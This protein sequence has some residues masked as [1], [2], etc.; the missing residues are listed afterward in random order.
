VATVEKKYQLFIS[1]TFTDLKE[2]RSEVTKVILNMY[3]IPIG[4]EMFSASN[5]EQW[6]TIKET[7]DDSDYYIL[8]IGHRYGSVAPEGISYTEKEFDYAKE[9]G[10]PIL[11]YIRERNISTL[12][13]ERESSPEMAQKLN[14]FI[15]KV[16]NNSMVEF[17]TN[18]FE[19]GQ[20]VSV[21]TTKAFRKYP[22]I[23][24]V[25]G[26]QASTPEA[27]E[28]FTTVS[29]ENR[30]L[31]AELEVFRKKNSAA[32]FL[33]VLFNKEESLFFE[34]KKDFR[35]NKIL[36]KAPPHAPNNF[37]TSSASILC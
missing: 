34:L 7:I 28:E 13:S 19:L 25:K 3:H 32:P 12:D 10:V 37:T 4:M 6:E 33:K 17:W 30:E 31:R 2:A 26:N 35:T 5:D 24:W 16:K 36:T 9:K 22:R 14:E 20:K 8:L 23:G 29:R 27:F 18:P 1:S 15:D 11:A 21:A